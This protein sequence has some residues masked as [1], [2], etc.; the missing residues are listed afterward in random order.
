M[1]SSITSTVTT[2]N[3]NISGPLAMNFVIFVLGMVLL[4]QYF[5]L[6]FH[7]YF[8][9][10]GWE[11]F[12]GD[13][14]KLNQPGTIQAQI[15]TFL[16][17][18]APFSTY[19]FAGGMLFCGIACIML[20]ARF[21]ICMIVSMSFFIVW[22]LFWNDPGMWFFEFVFPIIFALLA[23]LSM[24]GYSSSPQ[25]IFQQTRCSLITTT[26]LLLLF[27]AILYYVTYIAFRDPIIAHRTAIFSAV[28]FFVVSFVTYYLMRG[29]P[30]KQMLEEDPHDRINKYFDFIIVIVGA[31]LLLQVYTNY[32]TKVFELDVFR[33]NLTYFSQ[34]SNA[35]WMHPILKFTADNSTWILPVYEVFEI[36]LSVC[37]IL[38]IARGPMILVASG[39][40]AFLAFS[41]LGVSAVWPPDTVTLTWQWELLLVTAVAFV[42]ALQ[43]L[44]R[45]GQSYKMG[46]LTFKNIILGEPVAYRPIPI[47]VAILV[48]LIG[49]VMLYLIGIA[50]HSYIGEDVYKITSIYSGVT[51][52]VLL[53][54]L[55]I[56]KNIR[57]VG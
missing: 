42:I 31:M 19:L 8:T 37:L 12:L 35:F 38:L 53:F 40:L 39:L 29:K 23:G 28:L 55:L 41:E 49:G 26:I 21:Y 52:A 36:C 1:Q 50:A 47:F 24:R 27:S 17:E 11:M 15:I 16:K 14:M 51:F 33:Q 25:S 20:F 30:E 3:K 22:S 10:S 48:S 5:N 44:Y 45:L 13:I 43:K 7:N 9:P 2:S 32:F 6:L 18:S 56:T 54:I 4:T 34:N 57:K 46:T